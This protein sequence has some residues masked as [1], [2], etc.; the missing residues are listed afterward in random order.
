MSH[1]YC[2]AANAAAS[3]ASVGHRVELMVLGTWNTVEYAEYN[4]EWNRERLLHYLLG[5]VEGVQCEAGAST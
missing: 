5:E 4:D 1:P 3:A 2:E